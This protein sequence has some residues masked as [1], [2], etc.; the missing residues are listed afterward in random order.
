M[1]SP[2]KEE[3]DPADNIL[4]HSEDE[5]PN[6]FSVDR[7]PAFAETDMI[8]QVESNAM[9][10]ELNTANEQEHAV[11]QPTENNELEVEKNK[12]E[13]QEDLKEDS[14]LVEICIPSKEVFAKSGL[15]RITPLNT[16]LAN[17]NE[18][19][20][21]TPS[22]NIPSFNSGN[23]QRET[24]KICYV[25]INYKIPFQFS[26]SWKIPFT[27]IHER[28][29]MFLRMACEGYFSHILGHRNTM[30]VKPRFRALLI[31]SNTSRN[32]ER[33]T[34]FRRPLRVHFCDALCERKTGKKMSTSTDANKEKLPQ[35]K[36]ENA[37]HNKVSKD[38]LR[39]MITLTD[40]GWKYLCPICGGTFDSIVELRIH[41]CSS[42]ED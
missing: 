12:E 22:P 15:G 23:I 32:S 13:P 36:F 10:L 30:R 6:D 42:L 18:T 33:S 8:A 7:E 1:S 25:N 41:S 21:I 40:D 26:L 35:T 14:H 37:L 34:T 27:N 31:G 38:N 2:T 16:P 28:Q 24:G 39:V 5:A 9:D 20:P 3:S 19:N 29:R 4:R 11:L 17:T